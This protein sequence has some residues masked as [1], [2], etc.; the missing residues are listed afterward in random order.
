MTDRQGA[1]FRRR[2]P[3]R[4]RCGRA[5]APGARLTWL[6]LAALLGALL[7]SCAGA[8]GR[9][10]PV[11]EVPADKRLDPPT[12]DAQSLVFGYLDM[13]DAPTGLGWMEFRQVAPQTDTPFY[14]MRIHEGVF[15]M[16]K[17]PSGVFVMGE[18]GGERWDGKHLAY[19]LPRTS[20]AVR[21][22]IETPGLHFVG[23]YKYRPTKDAGARG[24]RFEIDA[25]PAPSQGEVLARILPFA[26]GTSW[27]QRI[28]EQIAAAR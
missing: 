24:G 5:A 14:Q 15:Y 28:R 27:E 4:P 10:A 12:N 21:V 3:G 9:V 23:A 7:A 16:E 20:P 18:F 25:L 1:G 6:L 13:S 19:A 8:P 17:F 11:A 2:W 22:A 26:R